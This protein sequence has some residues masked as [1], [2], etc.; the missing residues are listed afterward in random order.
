MHRSRFVRFISTAVLMLAMQGANAAPEQHNSETLTRKAGQQEVSADLTLNI[1][2]Q[3]PYES[4][5]TVQV[6]YQVE[7]DYQVSMPYQVEVP[8]QDTE[9]YYEQ[10]YRCHNRTDYERECRTENRCTTVPGEQQCHDEPYCTP[11]PGERRCETAH[12]CGTN[13]RG[14]RICKDRQVCHDTQPRQQCRS[15]RV[16]RQGPSR[17]DCRSEQSCQNVPRTRQECGY[18]SVAHTRTVNKTRTE[19]RYRQETRTRTVTRYRSETRCCE[20]RYRSE[21]DHQAALKA[22]VVFPAD[23]V[24]DADEI[25]QASLTMVAEDQVEVAVKQSVYGYKVVDQ[26]KNGALVTVT[27]ALTAKYD[28]AQVGERTI[29]KL[30]L[31]LEAQGNTVSFSDQGALAKIQNQYVVQIIEKDSMK[32]V[33]E[34]KLQSSK[35]SQIVIPVSKALVSQT[36]Y[37]VVLTVQRTGV[38]L[39]SDVTFNKEALR[40]QDTLKIEGFDGRVVSELKLKGDGHALK[41]ALND[42]APTVAGMTQTYK[43]KVIRKS[44]LFGME[45]KVMADVTLDRSQLRIENGRVE[46]SLRDDL[47]IASDQL[48]EHLSSDEWVKIELIV[49][50]QSPRLNQGLPLEIIRVFEGDI[51]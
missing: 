7:E 21:F 14:E 18:E 33:D 8:Y 49:K 32:M 41:I 1:N 50:R 10:E 23:A 25:E 46:I 19:T 3:V 17:Q 22:V 42:L 36:A 12:E 29:S 24:L 38:V 15:N 31:N 35:K 5:Y 40:E 11:V 20:T 9:T 16:C 44:G 34:Q 47:K 51:P 13:A 37:R 27:L 48:D 43:V 39:A 45:R 4:E 6:P 2:K 28:A 30:Q 26:Q